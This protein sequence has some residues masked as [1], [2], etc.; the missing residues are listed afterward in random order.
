MVDPNYII[1]K[2]FSIE[3]NY[4]FLQERLKEYINLLIKLCNA[5]YGAIFLWEELSQ[6]MKISCW[7][8]VNSST[9]ETIDKEFAAKSFESLVQETL[10]KKKP[11]IREKSF[12]KIKLDA[13]KNTNQQ[14]LAIMSLPLVINTGLLGILQVGKNASWSP[15]GADAKRI[16]YIS[17][18]ITQ[19]IYQEELKKEIKRTKSYL[20]NLLS[21]SPSN[22]ITT[23]SHGYFTYISSSTE[24]LFGFKPHELLGRPVK[25][26]YVGG[27]AQAQRIMDLLKKNETIKNYEVQVYKRD[28]T[29]VYI[30][31]SASLIRDENGN[32]IGTIGICDDI[33]EQKKLMQEM[34]GQA[35]YLANIMAD[36]ADAIVSIDNNNIIKSWNKGAEEIF[37]Y[38]SQ[39]MVGH[40][41]HKMVPKELLDRDELDKIR[42]E[43][44]EKGFI[45]NYETHRIRKDGRK[46]FVNITRT[47]IKDEAGNIIGSSAIIRDITKMRE[48][49]RQLIHT[50]KLAT[51]GRLSAA[52]AHEIKNPL[53]GISGAVQVIGENMP[54]GD[55]QQEIIKEILRQTKRLDNT[56]N[57]LLLYSKPRPLNKV[58]YN[59]HTLLDQVIM[60]LQQEP[61]MGKV[62]IVRCY[63]EAFTK[64]LIDPQ[65]MEQVFMN[66]IINSL[67]AMPRGGKLTITT[68]QQRNKQL[69]SFA[70]TGVGIAAGMVLDIFEPFYTTKHRGTGL[71]LNISYNIVKS[72]NGTIKVKSELGKGSIFTI[73][74]PRE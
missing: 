31:L 60:V 74:L 49:Q 52:L 65:Q 34:R 29:K 40:S 39:E 44:Y 50:E 70:D 71:G 8:G 59:I 46:I 56:I 63:D 62:E 36:S 24:E 55:S 64:A 22:I 41:F 2:I 57:H 27:E 35:Q 4:P 16:H 25:D 33:S 38:T 21:S 47:A 58:Y 48:L 53:A 26:F 12:D 10:E 30:K 15:G 42:Q 17:R 43:V 66:I 9:I 67:Q 72:H 32:I 51:I 54:E 13:K 11:I 14:I 5:T 45:R 73:V 1:D 61:Q 28:G 20:A 3:E 23:D 19:S 37:G 68:E 7:A 69:I 6:K 18:F